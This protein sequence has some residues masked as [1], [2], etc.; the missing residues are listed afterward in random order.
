METKTLKIRFDHE[1][2]AWATLGEL[3]GLYGDN[4][5]DPDGN[6]WLPSQP[7]TGPEANAVVA[8]GAGDIVYAHY[9]SDEEIAQL[10]D[11]QN[12]L[13]RAREEDDWWPF[14][15]AVEDRTERWAHYGGYGNMDSVWVIIAKENC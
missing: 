10:L 9:C 3:A 6:A 4:G 13:A 12:L 11:L 1:A 14:A 2:E 8:A 7:L 15:E 5:D